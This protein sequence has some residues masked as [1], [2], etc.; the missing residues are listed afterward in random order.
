MKVCVI[1]VGVTTKDHLQLEF[2][3]KYH[4]LHIISGYLKCVYEMWNP[5]DTYANETNYNGQT[6]L[7]EQLE[8]IMRKIQESNS[9]GVNAEEKL[10]HLML[11]LSLFDPLGENTLCS[12]NCCMFKTTMCFNWGILL[13]YYLL[14]TV[15]KVIW[16]V[17]FCWQRLM[18]L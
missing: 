2:Y 14:W 12:C 16:E 17:P 9:Y 8:L 1:N 13:F 4:D 6:Y 11:Q 5:T 18:D 10:S 15:T 3:F 7:T